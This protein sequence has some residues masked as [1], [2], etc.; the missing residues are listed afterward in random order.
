[1]SI[2]QAAKGKKRAIQ[3]VLEEDETPSEPSS[4]T[5]PLAPSSPRARE[6]QPALP[7]KKPK[8]AE[9]R[10]CPICEEPI[11][12]RLLPKHAE[13]EWERLE[14]IMRAIGSTEV[15]GEAEPD[16]GLS[17]RARRS[18]M[19]ARQTMKPSSSSTSEAALEQTMK[20]LRMLKRHRK[21]RHQRLRE[22]TRED[23]DDDWWGARRR[24][25]GSEEGTLCPVCGKMVPGDVDVVEAH[26][27][28]CLAHV[29]LTNEQQER[30]QSRRGSADVDGDFDI[31]VEGEEGL[32]PG[33][34]E[35]V[36]F[37]GVGFDIPRRDAQDVDE[38]IDIDGEDEAV[39]G[40]PQFTEDDIL[41][42]STVPPDTVS[43]TGTDADVDVGDAS[44]EASAGD[45]RAVTLKDL[46]A[47]GEVVR[48]RVEDAK[49]TM[50]EV[51]GVSDVEQADVAVELARRAGDQGALVRALENKVR[52]LVG[53]VHQGILV[54][55][56]AVSYMPRSLRR[57]YRVDRLLA[58]LLP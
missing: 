43:D 29:R 3:Q 27:D 31:D 50:E 40:A 24:R 48:K 51:M 41:G 46:V 20:T 9:T 56:T 1:M 55:V 37:R 30:R 26:V 57:T 47:Q 6:K 17:A 25:D 19:K 58:Y 39:F 18:A 15:L 21:Q 54:D 8:R 4:S 22:L 13:L 14:E 36:S 12:L 45:P 23:D 28:S 42:T 16:D 35:G 49:R 52:L 32:I 7:V 5:T 38:E 10:K 53:G 34:M 33:V 11:P 2:R 44:G